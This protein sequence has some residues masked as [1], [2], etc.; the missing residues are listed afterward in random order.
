MVSSLAGNVSIE[1]EI[2]GSRVLITI[3]LSDDNCIGSII[4]PRDE[5]E[6]FVSGLEAFAD[7]LKS[8]DE[9]KAPRKISG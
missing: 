5:E 3:F 1:R 4:I 9:N 6:K 2:R 8:Y 7:R